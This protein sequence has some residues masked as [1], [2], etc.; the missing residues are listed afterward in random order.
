[1]QWRV[2][3]DVRAVR[4]EAGRLRVL[5]LLLRRRRV[6]A[7]ERVLLPLPA[8]GPRRPIAHRVCRSPRVWCAP[9]QPNNVF[10]CIPFACRVEQLRARTA[11]Q[12]CPVI[13]LSSTPRGPVGSADSSSPPF[14]APPPEEAPPPTSSPPEPSPLKFLPPPNQ[15]NEC[16]GQFKRCADTKAPGRE[17]A[18][19]CPE[20]N[21]CLTKN[22]FYAACATPHRAEWAVNVA[23][24]EGNV[25]E[26]GEALF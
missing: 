1:M 22:R 9:G 14:E 12:L 20:N 17:V 19:C 7:E 11:L 8:Q 21:V 3:R 16:A 2:R 10:A 6:P 23:G 13:V 26:C 18:R 25:L 24:W 15:C 5:G 4:R